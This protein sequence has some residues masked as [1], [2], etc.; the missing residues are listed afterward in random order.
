MFENYMGKELRKLM[1]EKDIVY[2]IG[3]GDAF[4]A[5]L[6]NLYDGIDGV[7]S[8]GFQISAMNLG[9]PDAELYT[10]SDNVYAVN[11]MC[12]V[13]KK[14]LI[15]DI[16][17][18]YGNAVSA[19]KT[20]NDF[21]KAGAAAVIIEDQVSPKRCPICV[22]TMNSLIPAAEGANK[23]RAAAENRL[24]KDT[25][26]IARTD[27]TDPDELLKRARMYIDAGADLIQP[28]SR[29]VPDFETYKWFVKAVNFPVSMIVCGWLDNLSRE[30]IIEI[31][32][33]IAQFALTPVNTVFP[34]WKKAFEYVA[35]NKTNK[36][37]TVEMVNQHE[38]AT[39]LG[40]DDVKAKE[41]RYLPQENDL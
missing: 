8:S 4:G 3:V 25:V 26:I 17:T 24:S 36:G 13:L 12:N 28:I 1:K 34:I 11:N 2:T 23:I 30:E 35:T 20:V 31:G 41:E 18:A 27:A 37:I 7:L 5:K 15:A 22:D 16:D 40:M 33:K 21:E 14:P 39:F 9:L 6:A 29:A 19:I 10:R 38:V 32:P